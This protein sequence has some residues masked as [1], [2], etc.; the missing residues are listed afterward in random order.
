MTAG[1]VKRRARLKAIANKIKREE[2]LQ[3]RQLET[4]LTDEECAK[5]EAEWQEQF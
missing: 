1:C 2:N 5:I 3:N 4:W